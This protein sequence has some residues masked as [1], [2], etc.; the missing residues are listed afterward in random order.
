MGAV[1]WRLRR[2]VSGGGGEGWGVGRRQSILIGGGC[3]GAGWDG[4]DTDT[5]GVETY[6]SSVPPS[7]RATAKA[8]IMA[9]KPDDGPPKLYRKSA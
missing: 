4:G 6:T 5:V 9:T 2:D 8:T 7:S 3:T 1:E